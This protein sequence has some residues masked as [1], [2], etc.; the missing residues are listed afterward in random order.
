MKSSLVLAA[1]LLVAAVSQSVHAAETLVLTPPDG[2]FA[3]HVVLVS[4][5][6][7]YR[8]E[9]SMPMLA[10]LLSQKHGFKCT[11]VFSW[12]ADGKYIDPNNQGG[13]RGLEALNSADL[14]IIGTRFRKPIESEAAHL[15]Q[16]M[17]AGKPI[18]GIRTAT[19][20]FNGNGKFGDKI[21][22]GK[23]GR[24]VLGEQWVNHHG[25]HKKQGARG[26]I[27]TA[28]AQHPILNSVKDIFVP[29]DVYGVTHLTDEDK[30]LLRGA[31]TETLD[32]KSAN[33]A[34]E[35]ND[36]MQPFA[37][38]H[39][40]TS[41]G[42]ASGKSFCT[43]S[44]AAVDLV[45]EDL[46]RMIVN[47]SYHLTGLEVPQRADVWYVDPFYPSFYG[48]IRDKNWWPKADMQPED[49]GLGKSPARPDPPGSP[50][51]NFRDTKPAPA[52]NDAAQVDAAQA[53]PGK[54]MKIAAVGNSLAERMNL[55][56]YFE[57]L[58]HTRYPNAEIQFRN[59]GWPA[60]AV[61][62]QQRPSNYTKIDDPL[63][64]F[65]PGRFMC[66]FGYN[67]SFAGRDADAIARFVDDYRDYIAKMTDRFK[68]EDGRVPSFVLVGPIAYESTGDPLK[69]SGVEENKNLAAYNEA[70]KTL[71]DKD[72]HQFIDLF[73]ATEKLFAAQPSNQYTVNGAHMNEAGYKFVGQL[74]DK[75]L[76]QTDH[77]LGVDATKFHEVR[78][79]VNDKSWFHAQ[80]YRML[81]G[82]YVYG[83]R[84]T[85]D[86][87]TFP[88]EYRKVRK[89]V[90]VRDQYIWDMAAGRTVPAEPD[91]STTGEV[92][93]PETMYGTRD[94][95]FRKMREPAELKYLTPEES[96]AKMKVPEGMKV[97]LF[98]SEREFPELA[99]PNQIAFDSK[100]RLWVS[101]MANYPQW[102]PGSAKPNDR[103]LIFED[104]DNDGKADVCKTFY[105]KLICPTGFEFHDGGVLVVDEPRILFL[106]DTDGDDKA[107]VVEQLIDGIATD[108]THHTIGAWEY[109]H[110]GQLHMLE[111]IA[112]STT[113]ET[114][115]GPF[116]NK[117]TGGGYIYDPRAQSFVHYRTPGYG[118]PWC[119][120]FDRW[121]NGIVGDGT[122]AK[123]HWI[124][125]LAGKEVSTRKTLTPVFDNE[126]MRPAV[127]NEFLLSR[128]LPDDMQGQFIYACVINLHGMPRFDL[129]DEED[130]AGFTGKRIA[131]LLASDDIIFRPV[132]PKIGPDGAVWFGDWC[133]PLIGHMQY[134]Q[135]D[136]NRDH[137][138]GRVYR[139]VNTKK[140][141]LKP[142]T[143]HGKSIDELLDQL[144]T[145]E[146]R[147]RYR[148]RRE[149][150]TRPKADVLAAVNNWIAGSNDAHKLCQAMW[151]QESFREVDD[152]LLDKILAS[153]DYHA[154][155]AAVHTMTNERD[156]VKDFKGRMAAA[157]ADSHP[158]VRLEAVRGISF[159][160]S[161]DATEIALKAVDQKMDY[162]IDY[163]LE[164]TLHALQPYWKG[165]DAE[166]VLANSTD[167]AKQH[168]SRHIK[169][170]GPGGEV[171]KPLELAENV[172][173]T[174]EQRK[175]A[176][177]KLTK[178]KGGKHRNGEKVFKQVC[179]ACHMVG[180]LG[181]KFGPD[182][183]DIASRMNKTQIMTSILL[184][185]DE[186]AK[187]Y[188]TVSVLDEDSKTHRGFILKETDAVLT[189]GIADGK[190]VDIDK[191]TI[192]IRKSM[193]ASSM[194]EG[195]IKQIAPIEFL[196][197]VDY[198]QQQRDFVKIN[199]RGWISLFSRKAPKLREH[200]GMKEISRTAAVK[201]GK[202]MTN[203]VW[204][205]N[206]HLLLSDAPTGGVGFAFH[207]AI[208]TEKPA[209]TI[210]LDASR[211]IGHIWI[212]NRTDTGLQGRADGLTVWVSE[213][214]GKYREVWKS[215][216]PQP[217]WSIDL[218]EGTNARFIKIGLAGKGTLHLSRVAVYGK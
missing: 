195:L 164:H 41:P 47:A 174:P 24:Q 2:R 124:A 100:G 172:D 86:T 217:E 132:D 116:R 197:L 18:I 108:D 26:V 12:S 216:K 17:D 36:P 29:S 125:P 215:Q 94:E 190:K 54:R 121:G 151:I 193:K 114:P 101:C 67:E 7:E 5:D 105:D 1:M 188:E 39:S 129:K 214:D 109:S 150:A 182:L 92:F 130:G 161:E 112:L 33:V 90:A 171:V 23:W 183:S 205:D 11:V 38:L 104:T 170:S 179:S 113:L 196:D 8:S 58:M 211:E 76:H 180:T 169:M 22:F 35:K 145:Y 79:W 96:I 218:P 78:K 69:P 166:K 97:E 57:T 84:R 4:G 72:H 99:N 3:K 135:R 144:S 51:W 128:H 138:H 60:D 52:T 65:R 81:N 156:R 173:A 142:I 187:G 42:G 61:D 122:N 63:E 157:V 204:N 185:N 136:P 120:V 149:I 207:S 77:P 181:K 168:L 13:L 15:T 152:A 206:A 198:L 102:Q 64:V 213:G 110:G 175:G 154:R 203:S 14:M 160:E 73:A 117:G 165:A 85:W 88:S 34:G 93:K 19:H 50:Q 201:L 62:F 200:N 194:P 16:F 46:R 184:P 115:W 95:N 141:L 137:D 59:F 209:I 131:D 103:L 28:N 40:Y 178:I 208:D 127:G 202:T 107:D 159:M 167:A 32:P 147:T 212:Q 89:I 83:G 98:A 111:G 119:L 9:E 118:N 71:A 37:W 177:A 134:S 148:V 66:F 55:Y 192:E 139:L 45:S 74:L 91:D 143:Q 70:I 53:A 123:Q 186:I 189:L 68:R 191:D 56:G 30:I 133:N 176:I 10:K 49:Y 146:L 163:T 210:R 80:D 27:E 155:S 21:E 6:E 75:S 106:K 20:A 140:P 153:D 158:R 43:T 31:V 162:W 199:K 48:F 126:G 25:A 82:W 44:G 87:E